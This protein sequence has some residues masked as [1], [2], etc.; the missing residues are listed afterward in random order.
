M[1]ICTPFLIVALIIR[2][3]YCL[4]FVSRCE[5][6][7]TKCSKYELYSP[8]IT[9]NIMCQITAKQKYEIGFVAVGFSDFLKYMCLH[10][11]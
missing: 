5:N 10:R 7:K 1:K 6:G 4:V 9:I 2:C 8:T 3:F 11:M